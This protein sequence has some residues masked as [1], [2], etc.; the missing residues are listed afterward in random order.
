MDMICWLGLH[1]FASILE[2]VSGAAS[3][4]SIMLFNKGYTTLVAIRFYKCCCCCWLSMTATIFLNYI[5][6][7]ESGMAGL[8]IDN[9]WIEFGFYHFEDEIQ[10]LAISV[11]VHI[12]HRWSLQST[13]FCDALTQIIFDALSLSSCIS[14]II[15]SL[16][17]SFNL[18]FW[19]FFLRQKVSLWYFLSCSCSAQSPCRWKNMKAGWLPSHIPVWSG[20]LLSKP[21]SNAS[22]LFPTHFVYQRPHAL[23]SVT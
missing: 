20:F 15:R 21:I 3:I 18:Y 8:F 5:L 14:K 4:H 6:W 12:A 11:P 23:V 9:F 1:G 7:Q 2:I 19:I 13:I 10:N 16:N 22:D 17:C